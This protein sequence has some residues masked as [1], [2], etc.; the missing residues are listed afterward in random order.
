MMILMSKFLYRSLVFAWNQGQ[1]HNAA[2]MHVRTVDVHIELELFSD[3]LDILQPF[4][5][6]RSCAANPD[7]GL[8]LDQSR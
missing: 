8:V 5:I 6:I 3:S 2:H 7:L 1:R 4:L